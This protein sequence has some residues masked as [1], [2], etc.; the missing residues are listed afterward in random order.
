MS[1]FTEGYALLIGIDQHQNPRL[2]LPGV[3]QDVAALYGVLTDPTR[4]GYLS[5]NIRVLTGMVTKTAILDGFAW[6]AERLAGQSNSSCVVFY[7]GHGTQNRYFVPSDAS[8]DN[9]VERG[10]PSAELITAIGRL[11]TQRLLVILDCCHAGGM[12]VKEI[13]TDLVTFLSEQ[14]VDIPTTKNF[15]SLREG[16]GRAVRSSSRGDQTSLMRQDRTMSLFTGHL[17][18]A[19]RG[20]AN[21]QQ[22]ATE[23]RVS[24]LI[25]YLDNTVPKTAR[26]MG[27]EQNPTHRLEG[28]FAVALLCGGKGI[29]AATPSPTIT[30]QEETDKMEISIDHLVTILERSQTMQSR[31]GRDD[32]VN[33]LPAN[34]RGNIQR[35][36]AMRGDIINILKGCEAYP[37]GWVLLGNVLHKVEGES[38]AV[39][40]YR[41]A[42]ATPNQQQAKITVGE[43]GVVVGGNVGGNVI[44]GDN[45]T[46]IIGPTPSPA[47]SSSLKKKRLQK[48]LAELEQEHSAV[49][50]ALSTALDPEARVRLTRKVEEIEARHAQLEAELKGM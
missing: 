40:A 45:N 46:L 20:E 28:N 32:V 30:K 43:R 29:S 39:I 23:I 44:T 34:I 9:L 14:L 2:A 42:L 6:L 25:S 47:S 21:Y 17:V 11:Q 31:E 18:E 37:D 3:K 15:A 4:C 24:D 36:S 35:R 27:Y 5:E 38:M 10:L 50:Q 41:N 8:A 16:M 12:E 1:L 22:G 48:Q 26:S 13:E 19:L 33:A 49:T 7:S